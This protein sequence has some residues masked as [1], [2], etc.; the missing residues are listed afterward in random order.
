MRNTHGKPRERGDARAAGICNPHGCSL[1]LWSEQAIRI[2]NS[3]FHTASDVKTSIGVDSCDVALAEFEAEALG[4]RDLTSKHCAV[5]DVSVHGGFEATST[6]PTEVLERCKDSREGHDE[7]LWHLDVEAIDLDGATS[8]EF[9][10]RS[11]SFKLLADD[12]IQ[13]VYIG[14]YP[15]RLPTT[16]KGTM[17]GVWARPSETRDRNAEYLEK[18][19]ILRCKE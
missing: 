9:G 6:R 7:I 12:R 4:N 11:T 8:I 14:A 18:A 1:Y 13:C 15:S 2:I 16:Q 3:N 10:A 19:Y 17:L 5:D